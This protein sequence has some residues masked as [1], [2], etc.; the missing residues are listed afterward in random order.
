MSEDFLYLVEFLAAGGTGYLV[1]RPLYNWTQPFG[2]LS[3]QWTT[4]GAGS[5]RYD[6]QSALLANTEVQDLLR[7]RHELFLVGLLDAR[8]RAFRRLHHINEINRLR[9]KGAEGVEGSQRNR[10]SSLDMAAGRHALVALG[11][12]SLRHREARPLRRSVADR[13]R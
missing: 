2:S 6:F 10:Q 13:A 12:T 11:S 3:R 1:S 8:A 7:Q 5:W 9:A 4:T